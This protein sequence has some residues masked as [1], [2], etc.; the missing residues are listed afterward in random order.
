MD[1]ELKNIEIETAR[2]RMERERLALQDDLERRK[3]SAK[4]ANVSHSLRETAVAAGGV[5]TDFALTATKL[6]SKALFGALAGGVLSFAWVSAQQSKGDFSRMTWDYGYWM[7]S[8]GFVFVLI[9]A[10]GYPF[11]SSNGPSTNVGNSATPVIEPPGPSIAERKAT[12]R[13]QVKYWLITCA[14]TTAGGLA[15]SFIGAFLI[16]VMMAAIALPFWALGLLVDFFRI[17]SAKRR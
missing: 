12:L 5:A 1:D 3:R 14:V 17:S 10:I 7:G 15:H 11:F 16:V 9:C 13:R 6:I 2:I 4:V 8:G